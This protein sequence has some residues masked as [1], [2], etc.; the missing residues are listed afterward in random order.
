LS[1]SGSA[2]GALTTSPFGTASHMRRMLREGPL[3][4]VLDDVDAQCETTVN[5]RECT[6]LILMV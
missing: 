1:L 2:F 5:D 6:G 4:D 3:F